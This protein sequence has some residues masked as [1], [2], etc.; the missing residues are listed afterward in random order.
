MLLVV[1]FRKCGVV[2]VGGGLVG[3][4]VFGLI[5]FKKFC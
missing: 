5:L 4:L 1:C 3:C 2:G